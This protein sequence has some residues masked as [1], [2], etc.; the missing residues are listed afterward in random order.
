M[1]T[2]WMVLICLAAVVAPMN[3]S[4]EENQPA[5]PRGQVVSRPVSV[6]ID[7]ISLAW[8]QSG[9]TEAAV[10][11]EALAEGGITRLMFIYNG[12]RTLPP[13]IGPI[14]STRVYYG[15]WAM[16]YDAVHVHAGGSPEGLALIEST[17]ELYDI[18][19]L[20]GGTWSTFFRSNTRY[21]PYNLY[22]SGQQ[23]RDYLNARQVGPLKNPWIDEAGNAWPQA[24]PEIG[25]NYRGDGDV[26]MRPAGQ[27][28]NYYFI[29]SWNKISWSYD[30]VGNRYLRTALG[31]VSRDANTNQQVT[32]KNLVVIE[33][34][35]ALREGDDKDRIDVGVTGSGRAKMFHDGM[36]LDIE[37][38]KPDA[39]APMRF[40][41][42][43][44]VTEVAMVYGATWIAVVPNL[45]HLSAY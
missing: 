37:W 14:R 30:P 44:G 23:I 38:R 24:D 36:V 25:F 43:D 7:N 39:S 31:Q 2:I 10:V 4:A 19:G 5:L 18:D 22:T 1:R 20:K 21:A 45:D 28:I 32:T 6:M 29:G 17:S 34:A 8:P 3:L 35:S 12:D 41:Y 15:Q 9:F 27:T 13:Q 33:A 11:Y 42:L 16:G 26:A 40:Y